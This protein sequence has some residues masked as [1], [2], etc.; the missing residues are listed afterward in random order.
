MHYI[1]DRSLEAK[2]IASYD[3]HSGIVYIQVD[4]RAKTT[5]TVEFD[6]QT[7]VELD[8]KDGLVAIEMMKPNMLILKRIAKKFE[9]WELTRVNLDNLQKS[10]N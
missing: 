3:S 5:K 6:S 8:E 1:D 4:E 9:R 7:V 2:M 10:I